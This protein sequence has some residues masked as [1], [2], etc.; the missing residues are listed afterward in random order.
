MKVPFIFWLLTKPAFTQT[1]KARLP[2][3]IDQAQHFASIHAASGGGG[4]DASMAFREGLDGTERG[5]AYQ[6][7]NYDVSSH[8]EYSFQFGPGKYKTHESMV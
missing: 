8:H 7:L 2:S 4:T 5:R 1:F 3:V 6:P